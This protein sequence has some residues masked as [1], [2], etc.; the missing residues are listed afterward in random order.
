MVASEE[1]K[2]LKQSDVVFKKLR[3]QFKDFLAGVDA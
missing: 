1:Q 2:Q 3:T